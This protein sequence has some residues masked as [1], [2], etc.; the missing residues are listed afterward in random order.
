VGGPV[1]ETNA[2]LTAKK[3]QGGGMLVPPSLPFMGG[4]AGGPP[5]RRPTLGPQPR[6]RRGRGR[7]GR[8][9]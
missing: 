8:D 4:V 9:V 7:G 5:G 3:Y 6:R 1:P 2:L